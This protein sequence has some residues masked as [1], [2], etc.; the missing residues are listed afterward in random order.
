MIRMCWYIL[1]TCQLVKVFWYFRS[2][3]FDECCQKNMI[4]AKLL[5]ICFWL[6]KKS[7]EVSDCWICWWTVKLLKLFSG[8]ARLLWLLS[9][10][11][12]CCQQ[13]QIVVTE[14][15]DCYTGLSDC[16]LNFLIAELLPEFCNSCQNFLIVEIVD[17]QTY[18]IVEVVVKCC[19]ILLLVV[20]IF[21]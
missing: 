7:E 19:R 5:P 13:F 11:S 1:G 12:V 2:N 6:S 18:V 9:Q 21:R 14:L 8:V 17:G 20:R 15:P 10:F 16:C 3:T 4:V